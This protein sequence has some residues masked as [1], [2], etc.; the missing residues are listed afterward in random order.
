MVNLDVGQEVE[1]PWKLEFSSFW[2]ILVSL[3]D[4]G[5]RGT[6]FAT[7][8]TE[9][10]PVIYTP[11]PSTRTN[12]NSEDR[13]RLSGLWAACRLYRDTGCMVGDPIPM[14]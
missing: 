9:K 5:S 1:E 7:W 6:G 10:C 4:L 11:L 8:S 3:N 12:S 14:I 2:I 13:I